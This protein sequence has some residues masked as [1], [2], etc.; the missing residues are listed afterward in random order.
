MRST[1]VAGRWS[2]TMKWTGPGL[3]F[4]LQKEVNYIIIKSEKEGV[5]H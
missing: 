5:L 2:W 4:L 1:L 3:V